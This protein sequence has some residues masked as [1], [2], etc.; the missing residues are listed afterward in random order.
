MLNAK[1]VKY[2]LPL[3]F[4]LGL[5]WQTQAGNFSFNNLPHEGTS[6]NDFVPKGWK[7]DLQVSGD[8][9]GDKAP[10][11][12]AILIEDK[13]DN[14][15][16][17]VDEGPRHAFVV[18]LSTDKGKFV[19]AGHNEELL[20]CKGCG[21]VKEFVD[22]QIKKGI[23]VVSQMSGSREYTYNMWRFRYD[24]KLQRFVLIGLDNEEG[25]NV[26][27]KK[28]IESSNYLTGVETIKDGKKPSISKT[29]GVS[30][31]RQLLFLE[32]VTDKGK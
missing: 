8:L 21:G 32:D 16:S 25:D 26:L 24:P 13:P 22:I 15:Q 30:S 5:P 3:F 19:L 1:I 6:L 29:I 20:Q 10:D 11:I 31:S 14:G 2:F 9:N 4:I 7:V 12:A 28:K 27:D 17:D 23:L 18:L